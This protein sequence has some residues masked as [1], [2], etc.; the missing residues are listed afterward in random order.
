MSKR[1]QA[2]ESRTEVAAAS[3]QAHNQY[4]SLT[5]KT[6]HV[7]DLSGDLARVD[8]GVGVPQFERKAQPWVREGEHWHWDAC[9]SS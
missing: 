1:C 7:V 8:Y 5:I 9:Q 3:K 6:I 2:Q 4:G